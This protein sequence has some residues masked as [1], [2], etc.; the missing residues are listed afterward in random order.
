MTRFGGKT[1]NIY[2]YLKQPGVFTPTSRDHESVIGFKNGAVNGVL[3]H[4]A[5][6]ISI[7]CYYIGIHGWVM[8][9]SRGF[10]E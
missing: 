9:I 4:G 8:F 6:D 1:V 2:N 3:G 5:L 10:A 7:G